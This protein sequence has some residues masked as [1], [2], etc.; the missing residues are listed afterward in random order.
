MDIPCADQ[1]VSLY[2]AATESC[3]NKP[4]GYV[5]NAGSPLAAEPQGGVSSALAALG[6]LVDAREVD[7]ISS[8]PFVP[9]NGQAG[10]AYIRPSESL[11]YSA[12]LLG[13]VQMRD[14]SPADFPAWTSLAL[15]KS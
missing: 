2:V 8:V 13:D 3:I 1:I 5:C 14:V 15:I 11:P 10:I 6:A 7:A 9:E 12:F 4:A